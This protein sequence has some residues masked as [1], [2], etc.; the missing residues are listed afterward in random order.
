MGTLN[1]KRIQTHRGPLYAQTRC[2][3]VHA[4]G[5]TAGQKAVENQDWASGPSGL[6]QA[7][8]RGPWAAGPLGLRDAGRWRALGRGLLLAK[9]R[10][11]AHPRIIGLSH[12]QAE[13]TGSCIC[14][15]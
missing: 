12:D 6:S 1:G 15:K 14:S 8:G 11:K 9:P 13:R 2:R 7:A 3:S 5:F 4:G 10:R